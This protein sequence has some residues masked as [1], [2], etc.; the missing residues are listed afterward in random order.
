MALREGPGG[1]ESK[2]PERRYIQR[3]TEAQPAPSSPPFTAGVLLLA[4]LWYRKNRF[5]K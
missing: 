4:G 5:P 1:P 2:Y 3:I